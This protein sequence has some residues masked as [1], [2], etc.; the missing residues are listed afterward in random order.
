MV[1]G[2]MLPSREGKR[3]I[4]KYKVGKKNIKYW[5]ECLYFSSIAREDLT[6][7]TQLKQ[8]KRAIE[9]FGRNTF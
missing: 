1:M 4:L 9:T 5:V 6:E 3:T 8:M 2:L 7:E